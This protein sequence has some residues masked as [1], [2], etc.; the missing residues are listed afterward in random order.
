MANQV[1]AGRERAAMNE[2]NEKHDTTDAETLM[3]AKM[4]LVAQREQG[5]PDALLRVLEGFPTQA[6]EL[7]Q[8]SAALTATEVAA[9]VAPTPAMRVLAERGAA[10]ALAAAFARVP[11][12]ATA[13]TTGAQVAALSLKALRQAHGVSMSAVARRLGLGVDVVSAL[14]AGRISLATLP[15]RLARGL[16]ETLG[17]ALDQVVAALQMPGLDPALRR[18]G[19]GVTGKEPPAQPTLDFAEAVRLSPEMSDA[20]KAAWLRD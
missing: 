2:A 3:R 12:A 16:S 5:A 10:R 1:R 14:E 7:V 19:R 6:D 18:G 9:D 17:V 13:A 20:E 11:A 15:E 8:F 4:E